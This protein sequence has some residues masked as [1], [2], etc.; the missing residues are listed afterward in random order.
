MSGAINKVN[1]D[2]ILDSLSKFKAVSDK[3]AHDIS[4]LN[5]KI[6]EITSNLPS[7]DNLIQQQATCE[8]LKLL[9]N[10]LIHMTLNVDEYQMSCRQDYSKV[11]N[12]L[13]GAE[14]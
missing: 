8:K 11:I 3:I 1:T 5:S 13:S 2:E 10:D 6:L 4:T 7:E 12:A 14:E 9:T